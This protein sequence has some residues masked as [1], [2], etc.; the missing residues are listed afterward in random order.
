MR[1]HGYRGQRLH[2]GLADGGVVGAGAGL[3]EEAD[4]IGDIVIDA[5]K[6]GFDR[7]VAGV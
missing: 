1:H 2:A 7:H 4:E 5:E 6:A 3:C